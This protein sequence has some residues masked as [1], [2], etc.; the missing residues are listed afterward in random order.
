MHAC[1]CVCA[2]REGVLASL[3]LDP[4]VLML[5]RIGDLGCGQGI[6]QPDSVSTWAA[7][8]IHGPASV[9][10]SPETG[11]ESRVCITETTWPHP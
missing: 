1:A 9:I 8:R 10:Q 11:P 2:G 7:I 3:K 5:I 6:V 4:W